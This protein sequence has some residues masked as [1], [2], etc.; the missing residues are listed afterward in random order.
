[1]HGR[2]IKKLIG[3]TA[4]DGYALVPTKVYINPRGFV[5]VELGVGKGKK[6]YDKRQTL[7][8]KRCPKT[9]PTRNER[10]ILVFL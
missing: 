8:K 7:A 3:Y 4:Q 1:M 2:E 6:L 5:K 10:K 9:Y